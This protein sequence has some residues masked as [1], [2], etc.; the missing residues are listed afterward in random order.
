[1]K[2][3]YSP[4]RVAVLAT[5]VVVLCYLVAR[6]GGA[7]ILRPQLV[8]PLWLGNVVLVAVLLLVPRK[9]WPILLPAGLAGFL[10]YDVQAGE[11]IRSVIWLFCRMPQKFSP[12]PSFFTCHS[13]ASRG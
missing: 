2:N 3:Q 10:V 13:G 4:Q 11:P 12:P 5:F 8:S 7:L 1:M 6:V 9:I